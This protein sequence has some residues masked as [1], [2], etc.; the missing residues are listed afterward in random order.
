M[1]HVF[2]KIE[3]RLSADLPALSLG[4]LSL[5]DHFVA[6]VGPHSGQ[7]QKLQHLLVLAD[8]EIAPKSRFPSHPHRDMDILTWVVR[9]TLHHL[10][11][12]GT[13]QQVPAEH[14]QLM[15][16]GDGI[17]HSEGNEGSE[18]LRILQIWIEPIGRGGSPLVSHVGLKKNGFHL[19]AGPENAELPLQQKV[20]VYAARIFKEKQEFLIPDEQFAY[21]VSI[22]DLIW[23]GRATK[24]GDGIRLGSGKVEITGEGQAILIVQNNP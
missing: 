3:V 1:K 23:N 5:R 21:A 16:A 12:K 15:R 2:S 14:M 10:D 11:D 8:A 7:G 19:L 22:G 9:G 13:N 17:F 6:T 24:D 4:W 18:V 20:W